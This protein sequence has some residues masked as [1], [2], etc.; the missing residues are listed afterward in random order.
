MGESALF[1]EHVGSTPVPGLSAK[2][3]IDSQISV[4]Q[5]DDLKVYNDALGRIGYVYVSLPAP[6]KETGLA[7]AG[8]VYPFFQ[9]SATWPTTHQVHLCLR[10]S[11]LKRNT[12]VFRDYL[13]DHPEEAAK[14]LEL[15]R[16]LAGEYQGLTASS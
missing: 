1:V 16:R 9:R 13:K 2:P 15:K 12:V 3:V 14:Y 5:L 4:D 6:P 10:G 8:K 7:H 11:V